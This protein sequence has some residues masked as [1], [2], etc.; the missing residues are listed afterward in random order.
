MKQIKNN[1]NDLLILSE[2][3]K[4]Y[5]QNSIYIINALTKIDAEMKENEIKL[6]MA[7]DTIANLAKGLQDYKEK[8]FKFKHRQTRVASILNKFNANKATPVQLKQKIANIR[9]ILET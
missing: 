9:K 4:L 5:K 2:V 3:L 8:Y 6:N 1:T 7:K